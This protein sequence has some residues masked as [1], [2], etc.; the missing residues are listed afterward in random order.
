M[1][2]AAIKAAHFTSMLLK[3]KGGPAR[4]PACCR[5]PF[6]VGPPLIQMFSLSLQQYPFV[7]L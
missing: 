1:Q 2:S 6:G 7:C 5:A 3:N 4:V